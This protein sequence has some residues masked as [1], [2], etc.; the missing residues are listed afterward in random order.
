MGTRSSNDDPIYTI[1]V[2]AR[3]TGLTARQIRYYE[4][5][6]LVEPERS[7]GNQRL[8]SKAHVGR[9]R[10]IRA[11]RDEMLPLEAIAKLL[12]TH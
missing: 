11:L 6:G 3:L 7:R 2:A 8:F 5:V 12:D 1:G 10:E 4:T 9:L